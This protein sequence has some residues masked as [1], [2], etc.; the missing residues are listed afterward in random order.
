MYLLQMTRE[1]PG[2][3]ALILKYFS[4]LIAIDIKCECAVPTSI[5]QHGLFACAVHST[6]IVQMVNGN[7]C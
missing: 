3:I 6:R 7:D 2:I 4:C 5:V 1:F